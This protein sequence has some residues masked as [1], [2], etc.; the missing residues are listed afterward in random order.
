MDNSLPN[1]G[2]S[3]THSPSAEN[4]SNSSD[5]SDQNA[6]ASTTVKREE[7]G[8]Q[9]N[10][11]TSTQEGTQSQSQQRP[12][13]ATTVTTDERFSLSASVSASN[14]PA[15]DTPSSIDLNHP[16]TSVKHRGRAQYQLVFDDTSSEASITS[17]PAQSVEPSTPVLQYLAQQNYVY[18]NSPVGNKSHDLDLMSG[19]LAS[20]SHDLDTESHDGTS[21]TG[22]DEN[23]SVYSGSTLVADDSNKANKEKGVEESSA[24][25]DSA[26]NTAKKSESHHLRGI[27]PDSNASLE[28]VTLVIQSASTSSSSSPVPK[29]K[30]HPLSVLTSDSEVEGSPPYSPGPYLSGMFVCMCVMTSVIVTHQ[31]HYHR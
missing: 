6:S 17:S 30:V 14:Q 31:T 26:N 20:V 29:P 15:P 4:H 25:E 23:V 2:E 18:P 3:D 1:N 8:N 11:E 22:G 21:S 9:Q 16:S 7:A 19:D 27:S 5:S 13:A 10:L 24:K 28:D 12:Q